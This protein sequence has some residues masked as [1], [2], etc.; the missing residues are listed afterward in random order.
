MEE[1]EKNLSVIKK[2]L[3]IVMIVVASVLLFLTTF[4]FLPSVKWFFLGSF[5][6]MIYPILIM[7]MLAGVALTMNQKFVYSPIYVV[8][9]GLCF[10]FFVCVLHTIFVGTGGANISYGEYLS[11]CYNAHYTPGGVVIGVFTY[12]LS[13]LFHDIAGVVIY[14]IGLVMS[15]YFVAS[16]LDSVKK[17]NSRKAQVKPIAPVQRE[18]A[19]VQ[20]VK[21]QQTPI[22][23]QPQKSDI[24]ASEIKEN[25]SDEDIFIK[26]E[27]IAEPSVSE[28]AKQKL[29]L[30]KQDLEQNP[31]EQEVSAE[32]KL[33]GD[34]KDNATWQSRA[35][36][37]DRPQK[38]V[39]DE[40]EGIKSK[41]KNPMFEKNKEYLSTI[42]DINN[43]NENPIINAED[44]EDYKQKMKLFGEKNN[45]PISRENTT[46]GYDA[47]R[48]GNLNDGV[49]RAERKG[50]YDGNGRNYG[51]QNFNIHQGVEPDDDNFGIEP[52]RDNFS[53]ISGIDSINSDATFEENRPNNVF[54]LDNTFS[55]SNFDLP[56]DN[57]DD[58][59]KP[60]ETFPKTRKFGSASNFEIGSKPPYNDLRDTRSERFMDKV[61]DDSVEESLGKTVNLSNVPPRTFNFEA[62]GGGQSTAKKV[63]PN[64]EYNSNYIRPP[65]EMLKTYTNEAE[66]IDYQEKIDILERLLE[67]FRVP[68]KVE[69]VRRGAAVTRYELHMPT[70]ISVK[71]IQAQSS[72]IAMALAARGEVR[73]E[74]PIKGK[75]AVGVEVPN[76][77]IDT[78]GLKDIIE[79][80]N[81]QMAKAPLTFALGKDID[82]N[83]KLCN[84][85][86][87]P[88]LLVAGSTGSGKS[89][90]LNS[91][92]LSL[93][94][95][96]S[97][98]DLRLIMVDPKKVEFTVFNDLP[99]LLMPKAITEPRK[100]LVAFDWL[101]D[102]MER[103]YSL[104]QGVYARNIEEYNSQPEVKNKQKPKLPYIVLIVD[105]LADLVVTTGKKELEERIIRLTQK[106]RAAGIHL[107]LATQ[108]PSVD[109]ITGSIK[110]NLPSRIAFA[111]SSGFDSKTILDRPGAEKLLGRGDMLYMPPD[112][113]MIRVQGAFVDTPEV[114][115]VCDFIREHNPCVYDENI[116]KAI[117][118]DGAPNGGDAGG[119][120]SSTPSMDS[121]LP[122]ALKH[123]IESRQVSISMLQRRFAIG[124][125]RAA[126]II[127]QM[128][129]AG[130]IS[131]SDGSKPRT[132]FATMEDYNKLFGG[133]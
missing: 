60:D 6:I 88:H 99:H 109:I 20:T 72:D 32:S 52:E 85:A 128:E 34:S 39:Y 131:G 82:G 54:D 15:L 4:E 92:V 104:F 66:N 107:I 112:G 46:G 51:N 3:G 86:K 64:F 9:L 24:L 67:D 73:I 71:K 84:L 79:S 91:L 29:G 30:S 121:L 105:E 68:A 76:D 123:A 50:Y 19:T 35:F 75:S 42:H 28:I 2:Q 33:F 5:G 116:E 58:F 27:K 108:R 69:A 44:Y 87:M 110:I 57:E 130:F 70:G 59:I 16:Y 47:T 36:Y 21:V 43:V 122:D 63:E 41:K 38:F 22:A 127:D 78:V 26:D 37:Q 18:V 126:K 111:V 113:E 93:I 7:S 62:I 61:G 53:N 81:F 25:Q 31:A 56:D 102:E 96:T 65:V 23:E 120:L 129:A 11:S 117:M 12:P 74:A 133:V 90:C 101:I 13:M 1:R 97:P 45:A 49:I 115:A 89:V 48:Q 106:A 119:G 132:V 118:N 83:V 80:D 95:R 103:R 77:T 94:Y 125:Q 98:E 17:Q 40:Q 10:F 100:A 8:Y 55:P 124:Y 14:G 114:K